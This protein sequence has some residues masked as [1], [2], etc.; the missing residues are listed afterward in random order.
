MIPKLHPK[1]HSPAAISALAPA[2]FITS[3]F[4]GS[5]S[6]EPRLPCDEKLDFD[7]K[8]WLV[9]D[10]L[11][12]AAFCWSGG[13]WTIRL[14][15]WLTWSS[16]FVA[17]GKVSY[18]ILQQ[19]V[20]AFELYEL[21]L[22]AVIIF[23]IS[24]KGVFCQLWCPSDILLIFLGGGNSSFKYFLFSP[25]CLGKIPWVG[26]FFRFGWKGSLS[27]QVRLRSSIDKGWGAGVS[28][29]TNPTNRR[30][31]IQRWLADML[32]FFCCAFFFGL[33]LLQ[34]THF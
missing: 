22:A 31:K 27:S 7:E 29:K 13:A 9:A 2:R 15:S 3:L 34:M 16:R 28:Q 32:P 4:C 26:I 12:Y 10:G 21:H 11:R 20:A 18:S 5:E 25:R 6:S 8:V 30:E 14:E 1:N 23:D 24:P 19:F 17:M 33:E